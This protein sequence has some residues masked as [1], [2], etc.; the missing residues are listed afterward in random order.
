MG[1]PDNKEQGATSEPELLHKD[2]CLIH[3]NRFQKGRVSDIKPKT[4]SDFNSVAQL[5]SQDQL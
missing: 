4:L 1:E 2:K 5:V 3:Y